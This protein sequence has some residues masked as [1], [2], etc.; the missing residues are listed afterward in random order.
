MACMEMPDFVMLLM[1]LYAIQDLRHFR[2]VV[3]RR[4]ILRNPVLGG[5][6]FQALLLPDTYWYASIMKSL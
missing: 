6:L 2:E 1:V 5:R 3:A 4:Q